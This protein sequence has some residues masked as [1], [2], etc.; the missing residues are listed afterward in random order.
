MTL[1]ITLD[2]P[3]RQQFF[4]GRVVKT[5]EL[6]RAFERRGSAC[7]H[8]CMHEVHRR[9]VGRQLPFVVSSR[10]PVVRLPVLQCR[11][12]RREGG[13]RDLPRQRLVE[14]PP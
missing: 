12:G 13:G 7:M 3:I 8:A 11:Q 5:G 10:P 9:P 4:P 2:Q 1:G 14:M 6:R